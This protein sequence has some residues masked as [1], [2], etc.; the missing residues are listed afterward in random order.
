MVP[1]RCLS[2]C[3]RMSQMTMVFLIALCFWSRMPPS[4]IVVV[5]GVHSSFFLI[6][7]SSSMRLAGAM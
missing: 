2:L 5:P 6:S 7:C 1:I 4:R 3:A